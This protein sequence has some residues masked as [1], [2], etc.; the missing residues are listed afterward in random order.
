MFPRVILNG[1]LIKKSQ[2]KK[3]ISPENYKERF[4]VLDTKELKY[5]EQRPGKK[6]VLKGTVELG[7]I[8]CVEIVTTDLNI[9]CHYKYPFQVFYDNNYLYIFAPDDNCRQQWVTALKEETQYNDLVTKY[10]TSMWMEGKWRCCQQTD[11]LAMGCVQYDPGA[12]AFKKAPPP[13][14][15]PTR[16]MKEND[17]DMRTVIAI[18]DF[19]P[20]DKG[21]LPIKKHQKYTLIDDS[22]FD[23]WMVQ[24]FEGNKGYVPS[25][26]VAGKFE[27]NFERFQWYNNNITCE[28]AVSL[29]TKEGKEG[30][31]MVRRSSKA[32]LYTVSVYSKSPGAKVERD[33][34]VK[35]YLIRHKKDSESPFYVA[36]K[37]LF[38]TIPELVHYHQHDS[39]GMVT[40]LRHPVSHDKRFSMPIPD[41]SEGQ[42]QLNPL[43]LN[44]EE[45]LGC[46]QFGL[47]MGGKWRD[48]KVA[49]K[50]IKE[51]SMSEDE[52][53]E[54]AYVMMKLSHCK[55]VQLYG[56]CT[57]R[58]P[59]C[60]VF[61]FMEKGALLDY[62]K[63]KTGHLSK[64]T[65][66]GM[67]VDVCE[68]MNYLE[69]SNFIH[70][71]LAARNC[72]VSQE[73]NV[74]V[75][76]FGMA[77]F[78][79]DNEY[80]SSQS[81]KFPI[82]WS[83]P[84]VIRYRKYSSKSDVWSFGVLM[85]EVYSEGRLPYET[86]DNMQVVNSVNRGQR[87]QRPVL[88]PEDVHIL[89][90]WC[91]KEKPDDRPTFGQLLHQLASL[92]DL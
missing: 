45:T 29:L 75:S 46:G 23:W 54:E 47:V 12:L 24:D 38:S 67:C 74:K 85:W 9:P 90:K 36:E 43:E 7:K 39:A 64:E 4:F 61:E 1:T 19:E 48:K 5:S 40:R 83:A 18:Q 49:V 92:S 21:D 81:S 68:G 70:R 80:T 52:F 82:R 57:H 33:P 25:I 34:N 6:A 37:K 71:D 59:M 3:I 56:M 53:K 87:L 55:L 22:N 35:H 28:D 76:D 30:A 31:F 11:K 73:G 32:G 10:H 63:A 13:P 77:R 86:Q 27:S 15:V 51:G 78:L 20:V 72:L 17:T 50:M 66:L 42:W 79:L 41:F 84:E 14:P 26:Y 62:L 60:L 89:M 16:E 91:W 8:K 88:A 69:N 65:L 44:L 58:S 2:Q